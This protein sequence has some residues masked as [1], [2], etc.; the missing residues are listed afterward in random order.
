MIDD[1]PFYTEVDLSHTV[2]TTPIII[3]D[4]DGTAALMDYNIQVITASQIKVEPNNRYADYLLS[5]H[6]VGGTGTMYYDYN[7]VISR[8]E[9]VADDEK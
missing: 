7:M 2:D 8:L 9:M 5:K 3:C 6:R 4:L 1:Y